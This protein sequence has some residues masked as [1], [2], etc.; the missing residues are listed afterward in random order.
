[1]IQF[2]RIVQHRR[3]TI[4]QLS[5]HHM[6]NQ[7]QMNN[8]IGENG[9]QYTSGKTPH[10]NPEALQLA[11][12]IPNVQMKL[13]FQS[14]DG[15][16]QVILLSYLSLDILDLPLDIILDAMDV[17]VNIGSNV[18]DNILWIGVIPSPLSNPVQGIANLWTVFEIIAHSRTVRKTAE[19]Q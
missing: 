5:Y 11:L 16:P 14:L 3:S 7:P 10:E 17:V 9:G 15:S 8:N 19:H 4:P 2:E 13:L 18:K 1:M 6:G 12:K